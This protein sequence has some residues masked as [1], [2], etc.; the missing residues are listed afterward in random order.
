MNPIIDQI[1]FVREIILTTYK[2][3]DVF[4]QPILKFIVGLFVFNAIMG[5][6]HVHPALAGHAE[7]MTST[8]VVWLLAL[9]FAVMPTSLSWLVI[10]LTIVVQLSATVELAAV[11]FLFLLFMYLFYARMAPR[12]SILIIFVMM[13][14]HFNVPYLVPLVV[15]LYFPV[16]AIIPVTLGTFVYA[17]LPT[18]SE[19]M[20]PAATLVDVELG[21]LPTLL[22]ELA[23]DLYT[24][25]LSSIGVSQEWLITVVVFA[26]VII[27]IY[28]ASRQAIDYAKEIAIGLGC[29]MTI[30]GFILAVI[31]ADDTTISI[32]RVIFMT[33]V[34]G[35]IALIV[36]FFD[37]VLD[38]NR[39]ESVQFEDDENYYHVRIVPKMVTTKSIRLP[40]RNPRATTETQTEELESTDTHPTPTAR[41]RP[42]RLSET[43]PPRPRDTET[44][45]DTEPRRTAS[46][47]T[48]AISDDT[49]LVRPVSDETRALPPLSNTKRSPVS[50]ETRALPPLEKKETRPKRPRPTDEEIEMLRREMEKGQEELLA[51][52]R[53]IEPLPEATDTPAN[54]E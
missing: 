16:S 27:L 4:I 30:F 39:A 45:R 34:C 23:E 17:Q 42:P 7:T 36:R 50:D 54:E 11:A 48:R 22:P 8:L 35:I 49:R 19:L 28:V 21:D 47:E 25:L 20:A 3:L 29:L 13:A 24:T 32:G 52:T 38:Y 10:I 9:L 44:H 14:F 33:I 41:P 31:V 46:E 18:I 2:R 12:E 53:K 1:L 37:S 43:R 51:Q 26:L 15:G 40:H 6:D 5:L